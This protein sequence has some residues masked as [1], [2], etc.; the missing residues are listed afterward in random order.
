MVTPKSDEFFEDMF[1]RAAWSLRG[2]A[3]ERFRIEY[4]VRYLDDVWLKE[5]T[6]DLADEVRERVAAEIRAHYQDALQAHLEAGLSFVEANRTAIM[7]LGSPID[8][9]DNFMKFNLRKGNE[10]IYNGFKKHY[11]INIKKTVLI[12]MCFAV[13][14]MLPALIFR[15]SILC[16][17]FTITMLISLLFIN[18]HRLT[19]AQIYFRTNPER[20]LR[21]YKI[22]S[23]L[24]TGLAVIIL[25]FI[26][27]LR[28]QSSQ[29]DYSDYITASIMGIFLWLSFWG[30]DYYHVF[31]SLRKVQ[32]YQSRPK[33][34]NIR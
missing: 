7:E 10:N 21:R 31:R 3:R 33:N 28:V 2:E 5:A 19:M 15:T 34:I 20:R 16:R 17:D 8:A 32:E 11:F 22:L 4:E 18:L 27:S 29:I 26:S 25:F 24:I 13:L 14:Y 30:I 12:A 9:A 6:S 1:R 23:P